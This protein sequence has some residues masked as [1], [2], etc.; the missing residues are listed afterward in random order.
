M[1]Q[2]DSHYNDANAGGS[3]RRNGRPQDRNQ[4]PPA[5]P[6]RGNMQ[7]PPATPP[8][9]PPEQIP[10][11]PVPGWNQNNSSGN[12]TFPAFPA[13]SFGQVRFLNASTN[14]FNVDFAVD[15]NTFVQNSRFG[16]ISAYD[17]IS[18][19]FHT[20]TVRR[21]TSIRTVLY[22]QSFPFV[23]GEKVTMVLTDSESG[24]LN[25]IRIVDTSCSNI[26]V[27]ASCYRFANVSYSGSAVDVLLSNGETIFHNVTFQTVTPYKQA[28][29]G[30]YQF[31]VANT[32][33]F[34]TLREL[35]IILVGAIG[36]GTGVRQPVLT[37]QASFTAGR[38]YTSY[39]I[40]NTWSDNALQVLTVED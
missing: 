18:D 9:T 19:G 10:M 38:S 27:T 36:T 21:S 24:G 15:G 17:W 23:A 29:A 25:M 8:A 2:H 14:T 28:V 7:F 16:S 20:I 4:F 39:L 35:P 26:P 30:T 31:F 32:N 11:P 6:P 12:S 40:G 33:L 34:T 13:N 3:S 1:A 5:M 22:Q 37:Y